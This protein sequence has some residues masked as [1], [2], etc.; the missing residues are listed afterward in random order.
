MSE[1]LYTHFFGVQLTFY[2]VDFPLQKSNIEVYQKVYHGAREFALEDP[3]V[4]SLNDKVHF[5]KLVTE[6]YVFISP[7]PHLQRVSF[8]DCRSLLSTER[9]VEDNSA[10]GVPEDSPFKEIFSLK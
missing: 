6:K 7:V 9:F 4:L 5:Q 2:K 3:D 8:S 1:R 10:F